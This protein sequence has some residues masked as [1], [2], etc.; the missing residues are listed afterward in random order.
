MN[1]SHAQGGLEHGVNRQAR[2][3]HNKSMLLDKQTAMLDWEPTLKICKS[4]FLM[5]FVTRCWLLLWGNILNDKVKIFFL[6]TIRAITDD[7]SPLR[8]AFFPCHIKRFWSHLCFTEGETN[9]TNFTSM[10]FIYIFLLMNHCYV[11]AAIKE[12]EINQYKNGLD[13]TLQ[14]S[15]E[16]KYSL[17]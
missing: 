12:Q 4:M 1:Q 5:S 7:V 14:H 11:M 16:V 2:R 15:S 3:I 6:F 13:F 9:Y 8:S 10:L 17:V